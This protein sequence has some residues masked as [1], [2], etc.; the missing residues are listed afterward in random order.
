MDKVRYVARFLRS[1]EQVDLKVGY[2]Q[3]WFTHTNVWSSCC[4]V[5]RG[6]FTGGSVRMHTRTMCLWITHALIA[7]QVAVSGC[8]SWCVTDDSYNK[9][10]L[11]ALLSFFACC[12]FR[13]CACPLFVYACRLKPVRPKKKKKWELSGRKDTLSRIFLR[14]ELE[15]CKLV[16]C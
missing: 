9:G 16:F 7:P 6:S 5:R 8:E 2:L 13:V 14:T 3:S 1:L 12:S 11:C 10:G 15:N 4:L